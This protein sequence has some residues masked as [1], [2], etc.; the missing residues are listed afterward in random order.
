MRVGLAKL[1]LRM[2]G[3]R[4][5]DGCVREIDAQAVRGPQRREKIARSASQFQNPQAGWNQESIDFDQAP[6]V[7]SARVLPWSGGVGVI[8]PVADAGIRV[9]D[10]FRRKIDNWRVRHAISVYPAAQP[11]PP[12]ASGDR[13]IGQGD[14]FRA[15]PAHLNGN[16]RECRAVKLQPGRLAM[17][18]TAQSFELAESRLLELPN[19][20]RPGQHK[21]I[22][23]RNCFGLECARP[24]AQA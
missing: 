20:I 13:P 2:A 11:E 8:I 21:I 23:A 16:A 5:A 10:L 22:L 12:S 7:I 3:A 19:R 6:P 17:I 15:A 1:D 14:Q 9:L 18:G 24:L 4:D